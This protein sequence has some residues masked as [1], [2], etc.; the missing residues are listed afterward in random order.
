MKE[1]RHV[2]SAL[3]DLDGRIAIVTG[4]ASGIGDAIAER[5]AA[6]GAHV[7][8]IDVVDATQRADEL[9]ASFLTCDVSREDQVAEVVRHTVSR[10]G[11]VDVLV[12]NAG[13]AV[14]DKSVIEDSDAAYLRAF[15]VNTLGAVH[16]IR[17]VVPA[18][19]EG[20]SIIN[21]SSLSAVI[22]APLL[23]AYAASKAALGEVTRTS[24]LELGNRGIRVNAVAPSAVATAMYDGDDEALR[25]EKAWI[26]RAGA[27]ARACEPREIAAVVHFLASDDCR[28]ITGQTIVVDGGLSAGPSLGLL[29]SLLDEGP[30]A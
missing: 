4:A 3:F 17:C 7:V 13:V 2:A 29:N 21:I 10:F 1:V 16:G 25:R 11:R 26:A 6:A 24:A 12:N 8:M 22:G 14:S 18:M 27:F 15:R 28:M 20:G 23:G 30:G 5:F 9:G 19:I